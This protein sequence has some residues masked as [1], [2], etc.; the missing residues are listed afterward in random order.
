MHRHGDL[1]I[2][3][4]FGLSSAT[5]KNSVLTLNLKRHIVQSQNELAVTQH[6]INAMDRNI[7]FVDRRS[8]QERR[9]DTDPC[10]DIAVDLY[11]RMRRKSVDRRSPA[12]SLVQ[13]YFDFVESYSKRQIADQNEPL[14]N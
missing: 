7:V 4:H 10:K 14:D 3:P 12:K 8:R 11:H 9:S 6:R 2:P 1:G 5:P 13:D